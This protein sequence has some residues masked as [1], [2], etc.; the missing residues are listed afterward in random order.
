MRSA[1]SKYPDGTGPLFYQY[2]TA[3]TGHERK[4]D[5]KENRKYEDK[6]Q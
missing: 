6:M 5:S 4:Y 1:K 2:M 3:G